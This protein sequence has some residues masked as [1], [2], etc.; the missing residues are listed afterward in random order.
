[1]IL[2]IYKVKLENNNIIMS[3]GLLAKEKLKHMRGGSLEDIN[4]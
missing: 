2:L 1:M 4:D 3:H